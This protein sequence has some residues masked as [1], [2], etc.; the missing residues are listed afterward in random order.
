MKLVCLVLNKCEIYKTYKAL[1]ITMLNVESKYAF[2]ERKS[3]TLLHY[4]TQKNY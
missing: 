1:Q 2:Q 3:F 4:T